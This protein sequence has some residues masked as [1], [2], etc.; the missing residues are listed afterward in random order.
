MSARSPTIADFYAPLT[1]QFLAD[2]RRTDDPILDQ[3]LELARPADTWLDIGAGAGRYALPIA[4]GVHEVIA[5]D[6]SA[7]MLA[8]LREQS[9]SAGIANVRT[10]EVRWPPDA[11]TEAAGIVADVSL[12]A[13][14]G[15]DIEGDRRVP[16]RDGGGEHAPLRGRDVGAPALGGRR[17]ILAT[18]PR[19]GADHPAIPPGA[20]SSCF[21]PGA[22]GWT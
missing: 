12:I 8:A 18:H 15:H 3:L 11:L 21:M 17:A 19:R 1:R 16:G 2:P 9:A 14:V 13:S 4:L 20:C 22:A 7:G 10:V 6:P 5:L